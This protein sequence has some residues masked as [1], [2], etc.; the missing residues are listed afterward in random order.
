MSC[1]SILGRLHWIDQEALSRFI[2]DCQDE[3]DGGISDRPEDMADVYHTFFGEYHYTALLLIQLLSPEEVNITCDTFRCE[4][5]LGC[6]L[7]CRHC[8]I[9]PHGL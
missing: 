2:L 1:L 6:F 7:F 5:K 3:E 4:Y 8:W 9:V